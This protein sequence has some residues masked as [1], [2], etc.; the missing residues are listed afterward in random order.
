QVVEVDARHRA[1]V[2]GDVPAE[3]GDVEA[4]PFVADAD[5]ALEK[6]IVAEFDRL[7]EEELDFRA[8]VPVGVEV[9][10]SGADRMLVAGGEIDRPLRRLR[11]LVPVDEDL[12]RIERD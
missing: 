7:V 8:I 4:I 9:N 10:V 5:A 1:L 2:V 12:R 11:K 6:M 3:R